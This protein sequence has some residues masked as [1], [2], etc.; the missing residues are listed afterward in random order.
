MGLAGLCVGV[1]PSGEGVVDVRLAD[2]QHRGDAE[3][4]HGGHE[5]EDPFISDR[6]ADEPGQ[7]GRG[8]VAGMVVGFVSAQSPGQAAA[9]DEAEADRGDRRAEDGRRGADRG[10]GAEDHRQGRAPD[11][12]HRGDR[13]QPRGDRDEPAL[14]AD[15]VD[16]GAGGRLGHDGRDADDGHR[17]ADPRRGPMPH[18][19]VDRQIRPEPVPHIG[20]GD[21]Q[22]VE[23]QQAPA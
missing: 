14:V 11:H 22:G 18:P 23:G 5:V 10:L 8:D 12:R 1:G 13:D 4:G 16:Q 9:A 3:G 2:G 20:E 7:Q 17:Q 15:R 21:V 19:Q 6:L